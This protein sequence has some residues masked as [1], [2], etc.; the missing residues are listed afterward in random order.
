MPPRPAI[1]RMYLKMLSSTF[2]KW[3]GT[4]KKPIPIDFLPMPV[5]QGDNDWVIIFENQSKSVIDF[6]SETWQYTHLSKIM[7]TVLA[8]QNLYHG[9]AGKLQQSKLGYQDFKGNMR[10]TVQKKLGY[11]PAEYESHQRH[12]HDMADSTRFMALQKERLPKRA[13]SQIIKTC[14]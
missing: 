2:E 8:C 11:Q 6:I 5:W 12:P 7:L 13:F 9:R 4:W 14:A 10:W 1:C 3:I